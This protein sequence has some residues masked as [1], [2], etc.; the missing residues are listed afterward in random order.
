MSGYKVFSEDFDGKLDM[1]SVV[2]PLYQRSEHKGYGAEKAVSRLNEYVNQFNREIA[3]VKDDF[4]RVE[5]GL[6]SKLVKLSKEE[7][8]D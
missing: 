5:A 2:H 1:T 6:N 4:A 8:A 7:F 3:N